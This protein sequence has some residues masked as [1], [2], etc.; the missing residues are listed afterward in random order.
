MNGGVVAFRRPGLRGRQAV[1]PARARASAH[2]LLFLASCLS[3]MSAECLHPIDR[4]HLSTFL[5]DRLRLE[6]VQKAL[7]GSEHYV[8]LS[9]RIRAAAHVRDLYYV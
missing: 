8:R 2:C 4:V 9:R 7:R 3:D 6:V 5:S 1:G